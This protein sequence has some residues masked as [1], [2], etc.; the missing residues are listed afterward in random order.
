MNTA[1]RFAKNAILLLGAQAVSMAL[2]FFYVTMTG[3][4]LGAE[5]FGV[6][7]FGLAFT[8]IFGTVID[9]GIRKVL[10]RDLAR[11]RN[12]VEDYLKKILG[13]KL[14][15]VSAAYVSI[16]LLMRAFG[17]PDLT[18]K[19]VHILGLAIVSDSITQN[20]FAV[21]QSQ[22][23]LKF[24][25]LGLCMRF[26]FLLAG[27]LVLIRYGKGVEHF[28]FLYLFGS[29]GLL[30]YALL[31]Y[32][33]LFSVPWV[34]LDFHFLKDKVYEAVSFGLIGMFEVIYHWLDTVMLSLMKT[35]AVVGWYN[36]AYRL[37]LVT[38]T[39]PSALGV[40]L[41]PIM[42]RQHV[43]SGKT[44]MATCEKYFK[45]MSIFGVLQGALG[46]GFA[47]RIMPLFFGRGYGP[48]VGAFR[49]L[50]LSSILIYVNS[51]FIKLFESSDR[52]AVLTKVCGAAAALN[53]A[54]NF[55]LIPRWSLLGASVATVSSELLITVAVIAF[56][57]RSGYRMRGSR[58]V[59]GLVKSG[60]SG[61]AIGC[62]AFALRGVMPFFSS[63]VSLVFM[64]VGILFLLG[65]IDI[66]D[67][68]FTKQIFLKIFA[69]T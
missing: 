44:L 4:F 26:V 35:D 18:R 68:L 39:V 30:L 53:I 65:H 12:L 50:M 61:A 17:Y 10:V 46:I 34:R 27:G 33:R 3:R 66:E 2:N 28:A 52:Q 32:V 23:N 43:A 58:V 51:A 59:G 42:S 49:I 5:K 9:C 45:Y 41:F 16:V 22:D 57:S 24:E 69:R 15:L 19:V 36:A 56:S 13:L 21:F 54:L 47:D 8:G 38:V 60:L 64:Y 11:D 20:F 29:L 55:L 37:F 62:V 40:I 7:M 1:E 63:V 31:V 6:L 25:S 48:A 67:L 14:L